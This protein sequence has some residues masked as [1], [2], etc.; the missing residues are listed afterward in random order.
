VSWA[1]LVDAAVLGAGR[2]RV[3]A[4]PGTCAALAA[5]GLDDTD[6]PTRLLHQAAALSRARRAGFRPPDVS[7]RPAPAPAGDDGRPPVPLNAER[8]LAGLLAAGQYDLAAEWLGHL[9]G[10]R[11]PDVL[12]PELLTAAAGR[13]GL[14]AALLPVLGPL[15]GWLAG[16]NDEWAWARAA[17]PLPDDPAPL[18]QTGSGEERRALLGRLRT[19]DPAAGRNLVAS[20]WEA[21]SYRDRAAFVAMLATGLSLDDEP[22]AARALADRR[23]EVRGAAADLLAALPGSRYSRRATARAA[24]AVR[25]QRAGSR[26]R[27]ELTIP[28]VVTAEM[29]ADGIE[30]TQSGGIREQGELLRQLVAAA[31]AGMWPGHTGL[32][33]AALL[34]LA[35]RTD[36]PG[37]LRD[38]WTV[39]AVRDRDLDWVTGLLGHPSQWRAV[40]R[41]AD[42]G[43]RLLAALPTA[44]RERWL[45]ANPDSPLFWPGLAQLTE[46]WSRRLSDQVR[47]SLATL[48]QQA[49]G[50][51]PGPRAAVRLAA[52]RLEP[53]VAPAV[54]AAEVTDGLATAWGDM[55]AALTIRAA[56]RRELAEESAP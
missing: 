30:R 26:P 43:L 22:L 40:D 9:D 19:A 50:H 38:G 52:L 20:T 28:Q 2:S 3:P 5:A 25:V 21:D 46:P 13:P 33:P 49:P 37:A 12:V 34:A 48:A 15:A 27:L 47:A 18:W 36:W 1:G 41:P 16:F 29:L 4:A 10:R 35:Y 7:D 56:M 45:A 11:P 8:R 44:A 24:A 17:G 6:D 14:R 32:D 31:P 39:A 51:A 55:L 53:P 42:H 23:A 54:D